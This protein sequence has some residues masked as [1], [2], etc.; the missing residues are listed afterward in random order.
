[1][2][3]PRVAPPAFQP[4]TRK[5]LP[6][7]DLTGLANGTG[8]YGAKAFGHAT[9]PSLQKIR[10]L[11]TICLDD[12]RAVVTWA[13]STCV[14]RGK[15]GC[16]SDSRVRLAPRFVTYGFVPQRRRAAGQAHAAITFS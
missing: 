5:L 13:E 6:E 14:I 4:A 15:S 1:M 8:K 12:S 16:Y 9:F 11:I 7:V 2:R 10:R 3:G